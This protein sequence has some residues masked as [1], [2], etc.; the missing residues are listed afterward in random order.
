MFTVA[1]RV[2]ERMSVSRNQVPEAQQFKSAPCGSRPKSGVAVGTP[3]LC[4][5][6]KVEKKARGTS[7]EVADVEMPCLL[8]PSTVEVQPVVKA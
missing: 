5:N 7:S 6:D 8:G 1:C 3:S 2:T 4:T